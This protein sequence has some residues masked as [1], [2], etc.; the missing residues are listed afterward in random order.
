MDA[1]PDRCRVYLCPACGGPDPEA[2]VI[3]AEAFHLG[4]D[5]NEDESIRQVECW[6]ASLAQEAGWILSQV[7]RRWWAMKLIEV[8]AYVETRQTTRS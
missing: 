1:N 6:L 3:V 5:A 8:R 4:R 7:M 2:P